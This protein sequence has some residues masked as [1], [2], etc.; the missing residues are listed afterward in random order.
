MR[1]HFCP[2]FFHVTRIRSN[3]VLS[4]QFM[5]EE[6]ARA[7]LGASHLVP[8]MSLQGGHQGT[9]GAQVHPDCTCPPGHQRDSKRLGFTL[10][11]AA[12][13]ALSTDRSNKEIHSLKIIFSS[14]TLR[15]TAQRVENKYSNTCIPMFMVARFTTA[16]RERQPKCSPMDEWISKMRSIPTME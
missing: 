14:S 11:S 2:R 6:A 4:S 7:A 16:Q 15:Y 9:L 5:K 10:G 3:E 1:L 12:L 8:K 13:S